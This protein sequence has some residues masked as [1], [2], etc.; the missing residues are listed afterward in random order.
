MLG[1][2]EFRCNLS[3]IWSSLIFDESVQQLAIKD[4]FIAMRHLSTMTGFNTKLESAIQTPNDTSTKARSYGNE[5]SVMSYPLLPIQEM[6]IK[7][8]PLFESFCNLS[9]LALGTKKLAPRENTRRCYEHFFDPLCAETGVWA[10]YTEGHYE[11]GTE[12]YEEAKI[13]QFEFILEKTQVDENTKLIEMGCGNGRM[14][15]RAKEVGCEAPHGITLSRTQA[16]ACQDM[17]L[18]NVKVMNFFDAKENYDA[19]SFDVVIMNG[20]TEH[21]VTEE[22]VLNGKKDDIHDKIFETASSLLKPG[23]RLFITCIH[24]KRDIAIQEISKSPLKHD[25]GSYNFHCSVLVGL[26]SGW[27]PAAGDYERAAHKNGL[28]KTFDRDATEDY[29]ITSRL[30]GRKLR[31]FL[32]AKENKG[33]RNKF[34]TELF[35]KDP[36][37]FFT[38]CL[39]MLYD[40]WTWQFRPR[41]GE[42]PMVHR[43]LMFEKKESK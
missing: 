11:N 36:N 40:S 6:A 5:Q 30:W 42:T 38:T 13:K 24:F 35:F 26:Y 21:F 22:D 29:Y 16:K 10:D 19:E 9:S 17:G 12:T 23:G 34:L 43:W 25:V 8:L 31:S 14:L 20:P 18:S 41:N 2:V 15:E 39:F 3:L 32:K 37:Y 28:N 7:W 4:Q 1:V 27:Y 33:F